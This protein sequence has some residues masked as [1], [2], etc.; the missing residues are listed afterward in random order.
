VFTSN[1][2]D[3]WSVVL[4]RKGGPFSVLAL[5]PPDPSLN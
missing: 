2:Y 5:M 1:P 3:L 4:R